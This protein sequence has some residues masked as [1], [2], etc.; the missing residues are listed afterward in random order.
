[1][2]VATNPYAA[3]PGEPDQPRDVRPLN[4][5]ITHRA[6]IVPEVAAF[7]DRLTAAVES[8]NWGAVA[9]FAEEDALREQMQ[10]LVGEGMSPR[11][12][13]AEALAASLGFDTAI[14]PLF[15]PG[16]DR[17]AE[18]FAGLDRVGNMTVQRVEPDPVAG[19]TWATGYIR[20]DDR[21]TP[22]FTFAV[23]TS[24]RGPRLV[25]PRG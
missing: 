13:G 18:P 21:S 9:L 10:F 20:L 8:G 12:A 22:A 11:R 25:V 5:R 6:P 4:A 3:F 17:D 7:L 23:R 2:D 15:P 16:A 1:V 14:G 24:P 19:V